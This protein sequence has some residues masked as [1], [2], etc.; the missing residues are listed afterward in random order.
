MSQ[1]DDTLN[2]QDK[3]AAE[4]VGKEMQNQGIESVQENNREIESDT[5]WQDKINAERENDDSNTNEDAERG[6]SLPEEQETNKL[7]E[8]VKDMEK[9]KGGHV[10]RLEQERAAEKDEPSHER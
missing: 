9:E 6:R 2:E 8:A 10:E 5:K 3:I 4:Q 7:E 1:M